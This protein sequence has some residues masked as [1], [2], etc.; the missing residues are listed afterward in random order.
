MLNIKQL[1]VTIGGK[2]VVKGLDLVLEPGKVYALMGPNG[3]GKS[4]LAK[5]LLGHPDTEVTGGSVTIDGKNALDMKPYERA[6]A[7]LFLSFQYPEE[8]PG[9]KLSSFLRTAYN[10]LH[11]KKL[12]ILQ[13]RRVLKEKAALLNMREE[14]LDRSLNQG[15]SGGEKKKA[16]ILQLLVLNP[17]YAILDE[18][19]SGLDI[20]ALAAVCKGVN[21]FKSKDKAIL[22]ITHY[23]RI[24]DY[25]QPDQVLVMQDGKITTTGDFS[26]VSELE[27]KGYSWLE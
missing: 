10:T 4:T 12:S 25:I 11:E 22:V 26:L 14:L 7:G 2:E 15:F 3:S 1:Y 8:I 27:E 24:L 18:T 13:F 19:D 20:D 17:T 5:T 6:G 9:L 21:S 23:R 16:E